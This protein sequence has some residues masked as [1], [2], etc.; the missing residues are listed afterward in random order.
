MGGTR[1]IG[2]SV[3]G[4]TQKRDT[5]SSCGKLNQAI[6]EIRNV[7]CWSLHTR[8]HMERSKII[9]LLICVIVTLRA[10]SPSIFL[11]N[12]DLSRKIEGDSARR[13][14]DSE[15]LLGSNDAFE[16]VSEID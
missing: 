2:P 13:V 1:N 14:C 15:S 11:T 9:I 5:C 7:L 16:Q 3:G 12:R 8:N 4:P 6:G 10:E